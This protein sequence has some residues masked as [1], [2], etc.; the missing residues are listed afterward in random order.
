M[1]FNFDFNKFGKKRTPAD[2]MDLGEDDFDY[3]YADE[4]DIYE[5]DDG[6]GYDI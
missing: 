1:A 4:F 3:E 2:Y 5:Y 6:E